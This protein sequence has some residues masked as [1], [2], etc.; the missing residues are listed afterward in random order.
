MALRLRLVL[1]VAAVVGA[2][3]GAWWFATQRPV[4]VPVA[5]VER[6]VPIR[7][8]GL[9]TV[10]A[11]VLSRI[12]FEVPGMLVAVAADHGDAVSDGA[13]LAKLDTATQAAR[14]T[15]AEALVRS[16]MAAVA[17]ACSA[18]IAHAS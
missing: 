3:V 15:R 14:V 10:E 12:G 4:S 7:V 6:D 16:A 13:V 1:T 2:A 9:G 8:F 18:R 17:T 5:A 11:R